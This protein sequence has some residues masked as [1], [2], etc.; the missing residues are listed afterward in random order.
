MCQGEDSPSSAPCFATRYYAT[1]SQGLANLVRNGV[2]LLS[3]LKLMT[4][5]TTNHYFSAAASE[6]SLRWCEDGE[7]FSAALKQAKGFPAAHGGP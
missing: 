1:L 7:A 3:A 2:P 4:R 6:R 5:A